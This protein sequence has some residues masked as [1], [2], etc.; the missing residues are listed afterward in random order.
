MVNFLF[1]SDFSF[2]SSQ[3]KKKSYLAL[4]NKKK[5]TEV[6]IFVGVDIW[7]KQNVLQGSARKEVIELVK[8]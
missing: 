5:K 4:K 7:N 2:F 8:M 6:R 3:E 1:V